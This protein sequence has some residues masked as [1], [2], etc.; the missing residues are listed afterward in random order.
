MCTV[1]L[2]RRPGHAWP[3]L[4]AA[5]RD[6]RLDRPADPPGPYWD[7]LVGGRDRL[8]G[9]SWMAMGA[10]GV[11]ACVLNREGSLGPAP[12]KASRGGLPLLAAAG[13]DAAE[14][15]AR[16]V[17]LDAGD[18]R[19]FNAVVADRH[20]AFFIAGLGQGRAVAAPLPD[21]LSMLATTFPDDPAHPRIARNRPGFAAAPVPE[22]PDWRAWE[23][24]LADPHGGP[25]EQLF[26]LPRDG[27]GTVSSSLFAFGLQSLWRYRDNDTPWRDIALPSPA[28]ATC[29]GLAT[30]LL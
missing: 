9:G 13:R 1:L 7:G 29:G 24:L 17:A 22:P 23:A 5:N 26:V 12:G 14:G 25:R 6:E 28:R 21:G 16:L 3:L 15:A 18:Y 4:L 8:G 20:A 19:P 27:F 11:I 10:C 2:L 30:P